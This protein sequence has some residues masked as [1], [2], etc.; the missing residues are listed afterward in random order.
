MVSYDAEDPINAQETDE[1]HETVERN[2]YECLF[3]VLHTFAYKDNYIN[4]CLYVCVLQWRPWCG[5]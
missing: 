3:Q 2:V 1:T 5:W 4:A